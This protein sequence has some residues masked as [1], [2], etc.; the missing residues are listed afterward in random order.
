MIYD[1]LLVI[2][3]VIFALRGRKK[4]LMMSIFGLFSVVISYIAAAVLVKPASEAFKQTGMYEK[5]LEKIIEY[6]P[7]NQAMENIPF[8]SDAQSAMMEN[9]AVFITNIIVS[10]V[11]FA[12]VLMVL[13]VVIKILNGVFKLPVLNFFNKT[14]GMI[15]GLVSGFLICYA[16][17]AAWGAY[18]LFEIPA[19]I[20]TST[21]VKS[22]FENNLLF[23]LIA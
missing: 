16:I 21:L 8:V 12:V 18:T 9:M 19:G 4:G 22:M 7:K 20:E 11:I 1:I 5:L 6:I 23:L 2:I 14:G 3:L 17:L 13:K 15:F 10:V